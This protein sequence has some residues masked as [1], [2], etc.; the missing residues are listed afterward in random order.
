MVK[1]HSFVNIGS[2]NKAVMWEYLTACA[3]RDLG[4][5]GSEY[6]LTELLSYGEKES[7]QH[8]FTTDEIAFDAEL[9]MKEAEAGIYTKPFFKDLIEV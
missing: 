6:R 8:C 2:R 7:N 1:P 5:M 3:Y 9:M 4:V